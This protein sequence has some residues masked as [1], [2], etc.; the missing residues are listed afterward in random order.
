MLTGLVFAMKKRSEEGG[1]GGDDDDYDD[2]DDQKHE[3][4]ECT[5]SMSSRCANSA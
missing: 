5:W 2:A 4:I 3:Y 1:G